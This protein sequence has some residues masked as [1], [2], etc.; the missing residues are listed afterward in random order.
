MISKKNTTI[1]LLGL[2][3]A[4]SSLIALDVVGEEVSVIAVGKMAQ[5]EK[6]DAVLP[7]VDD[8]E[9][10]TDVPVLPATDYSDAD[11][12]MG[13]DEVEDTSEVSSDVHA[14]DE[15][16]E[17]SIAVEE[18]AE[19]EASVDS[20]ENVVAAMDSSL[21]ENT[22]FSQDY[23]V[24]DRISPEYIEKNEADNLKKIQDAYDKRILA[25]EAEYNRAVA[26]IGEVDE[27]VFVNVEDKDLPIVVDGAAVEKQKRS[28][29]EKASHDVSA[30][31]DVKEVFARIP[32]GG[33]SPYKDG[34]S[35][36]KEVA[37]DRSGAVRGGVLPEIKVEDMDPNYRTDKGIMVVDVEDHV[38]AE[39]DELFRDLKIAHQALEEGDAETAIAYFKRAANVDPQYETRFGLATA[40]HMDEQSENA[41]K[42][43]LELIREDNNDWRVLNNLLL[44]AG[45]RADTET[46][47]ELAKME[48]FN[49]EFAAI[50]AHMGMLYTERA[51]YKKAAKKFIRAIELEPGN[52]RYR[53]NLALVMEKVGNVAGAVK[54]YQQLLFAGRRGQELPVPYNEL[55]GRVEHLAAS[56]VFNK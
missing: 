23:A 30:I 5:V 18:A 52:M 35:V 43:Y 25:I 14:S 7:F 28:V 31:A 54:L 44:I 40:Y 32:A 11:L 8:V 21:L 12:D 56:M 47:V 55:Q 46:L 17:P 6:S 50:P 29:V 39:S 1:C 20:S 4:S 27:S 24:S 53:Y 34:L 33:L 36:K 42:L 37:M 15:E 19:V 26:E 13:F 16:D 3:V 22:T 10:V 38:V 2:L 49:T 48:Q 45:Q 41:K 9:M 51:E